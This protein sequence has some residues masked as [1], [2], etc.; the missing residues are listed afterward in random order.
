MRA[1]LLRLFNVEKPTYLEMIESRG[2]KSALWATT[3]CAI[4]FA[5]L[6][7][8]PVLHQSFWLRATASLVFKRKLLTSGP[9]ISCACRRAIWLSTSQCY[10]VIV[11]TMVNELRTT[12]SDLRRQ[13]YWW[14][15]LAWFECISVF[16]RL[17]RGHSPIEETSW[18]SSGSLL[19]EVEALRYLVWGEESCNA[20]RISNLLPWHKR[21]SICHQRP[22]WRKPFQK[23]NQSTSATTCFAAV[24]AQAW[25]HRHPR[26]MRASNRSWGL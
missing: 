5:L 21:T 3:F 20:L 25:F 1:E 22:P 8:S 19:E 6:H 14:L 11:I 7:D 9:Q 4:N 17:W 26:E 15:Q 2:V 10:N 24:N 18:G 12:A 16:H 13:W 23:L